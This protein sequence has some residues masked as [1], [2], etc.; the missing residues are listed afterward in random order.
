MI[1]WA[2][3]FLNPPLHQ[4]HKPLVCENTSSHNQ[5][6]KITSNNLTSLHYI[7]FNSS[8]FEIEKWKVDLLSVLIISIKNPSC[9]KSRCFTNALTNRNGLFSLICDSCVENV[10][11]SRSF[12]LIKS[13]FKIYLSP[14]KYMNGCFLLVD[15]IDL[16]TDINLYIWGKSEEVYLHSDVMPNA[17]LYFMKIFW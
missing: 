14:I 1:Y 9:V 8:R 6:T 13:M 12:P 10:T 4:T 17:S 15:K 16:N 3:V 11:W 5:L 2:F 7:H